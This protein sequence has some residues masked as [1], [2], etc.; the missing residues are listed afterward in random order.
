MHGDFSRL[1]ARPRRYDGVYLQ[2]G[3]MLLDADWNEQTDLTR[4]RLEEALADLVGTGSPDRGGVVHAND[5]GTVELRWGR[6]HVDGAQAHLLPDDELAPTAAAFVYEHQADY[7]QPPP[8]PD[9]PHVLYVDVWDRDLGVL[10]DPDLLEPALGGADTTRRSR[11]VAQVKWCPSKDGQ[12]ICLD[13]DRNPPRGTARLEI[14]LWDEREE[15]DPCDPCAGEFELDAEVSNELF[16]LE[17]HDVVGPANA[18]DQVTLKWSAENA[19]EAHTVDALPTG[20]RSESHAYEFFDATSDLQLGVRLANEAPKRGALRGSLPEEPTGVGPPWVR[21]WDGFCTL[22]R[23]SLGGWSLVGDGD[24]TLAVDAGGVLS[25]GAGSATHG[26]VSLG[27][28]FEVNLRSLVIRL[29][30]T[31][32]RFVAGDHWRAT[33]RQDLPDEA[34]VRLES[35]EPIGPVHHIAVLAYDRGDGTLTLADEASRRALTFPRLSALD[36]DHVAYTA[37]DG[38]PSG[39]FGNSHDTVRRALDRLCQ[40]GADHVAFTPP[41]DPNDERS[42]FHGLRETTVETALARL[43]EIAAEIVTYTPQ[44]GCSALGGAA[45]V[46]QA[47]DLICARLDSNGDDCTTR[48]TLFG[49]GVLCGLVPTTQSRL[50]TGGNVLVTVATTAGTIIDA[51]GCIT[52]VPALSLDTAVQ[53]FTR[54]F[55]IS[56]AA[57]RNLNEA[58]QDLRTTDSDEL[59]RTA[60][61]RHLTIGRIDR[62]IRTIEG[63]QFGSAGEL[64]AAVDRQLR[65]VEMADPQRE[66]LISLTIKTIHDQ[67]QSVDEPI[68]EPARRWLQLIIPQGGEPTLEL[69]SSEPTHLLRAELMLGT[70]VVVA[71]PAAVLDSGPIANV[72]IHVSPVADACQAA[73]EAAWAEHQELSCPRPPTNGRT[74]ICLGMIGV[75]GTSVWSCP[76]NREDIQTPA[77]LSAAHRTARPATFDKIAEACTRRTWTAQNSGTTQNLWSVAFVNASRGWAVGNTGTI[78]A[79]TNG[80]GTWTAQSSGTTAQSVAFVDASRGWAVGW[81]GTILATTNGGATWTAQS[82]GTTTQGLL[83]VAFV[84]ASRGWAVGTNGTILATTNGG[85]TWTAQSYGTAAELLSVAFVDASRGWAVG[86]GGTILVTTNGGATWTAQSSGTTQHL[87]SVAFVDASRGWAVGAV[88]TIL[89]TTNGGATWTAQSS[90]TTQQLLSVAF[91]DASRGWAVGAGGTIL[92]YR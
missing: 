88:G 61:E 92:T 62:V 40:L 60:I 59:S 67:L 34:A 43:C 91:V 37:P 6:I 90:G 8:R 20:F 89:V 46:Q 49:R 4:A 5:D 70:E 12:P 19:S 63:R 23:T 84:D 65:D 32:S 76:D 9:G 69:R 29:Q 10:E 50:G 86:L 41:C 38:G 73:Q 36:A 48:L 66:A 81:G 79:T 39:L 44:D 26:H 31:D 82:S 87:R 13:P 3:R 21:R 15:S 27:D 2:Q 68:P 18:P 7:P 24:R 77:R 11:T 51:F 54:H 78:L 30:L 14:E 28:R 55:D 35:T 71:D 17:V 58:L 1:P 52:D 45:S 74:D 75:R 22:A 72:G 80:G 47:L 53:G 64:N 85:A 83:S 16:R 57:A 42:P 56:P 25:T 33:I